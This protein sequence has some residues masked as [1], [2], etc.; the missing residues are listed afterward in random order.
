MG[1][2]HTFSEWA[3]ISGVTR[4]LIYYRISKGMSPE[5]ALLT[6]V[7]VKEKKK[8]RDPKRSSAAYKVA[9]DLISRE[10]MQRYRSVGMWYRIFTLESR[11]AEMKVA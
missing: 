4:E 2:T 11:D 5:D 7:V 6:P 10:R 1:E 9:L 8:F 3:E